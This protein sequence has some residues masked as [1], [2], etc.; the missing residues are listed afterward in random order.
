MNVGRQRSDPDLTGNPQRA[1]ETPLQDR[2]SQPLS[3]TAEDRKSQGPSDEVTGDLSHGGPYGMQSCFSIGNKNRVHFQRKSIQNED[4][5]EEVIPAQGHLTDGSFGMPHAGC[6]NASSFRGNSTHLSSHPSARLQGSDISEGHQTHRT[7]VE[8]HGRHALDHDNYTEYLELPQVEVRSATAHEDNGWSLTDQISASSSESSGSSPYLRAQAFAGH[9]DTFAR[10]KYRRHIAPEIPPSIWNNVLVH[11]TQKDYLNLRLSSKVWHSALP[12]P[13]LRATYYLPV[14]IIQQVYHYLAPQDFNAARHTCKNWYIAALDKELLALTLRKGGWWAAAEA[15]IELRTLHS[16]QGRLYTSPSYLVDGNSDDGH[17]SLSDEIWLLSKRLTIECSL[18]RGWK[19]FGL[20]SLSG[21]NRMSVCAS[22]DF[23]QLLGC[24]SQPSSASL[25]RHFTTSTCGHFVL[26][27]KDC[28]VYIYKLS[29]DTATLQGVTSVVCPR[30]VLAVSMDTS[31]RRYAIAALLEGRMG[32]VCDV[33]NM[34]P[35]PVAVDSGTVKSRK[36]ISFSN[37]W[38]TDPEFDARPTRQRHHLQ[39]QVATGAGWRPLSPHGRAQSTTSSMP[40]SQ[41]DTVVTKTAYIPN[42]D[43]A[44]PVE[45]GQR[46]IYRNLCSIDDPPRSVAICPERRCVAFGSRLGIELHWVDALSG[47]DLN[48]LVPLAAPSDHLYFL[49]PRQ[50][51]DSAKKL[52]LI[53]SA[54]GPEHDTPRDQSENAQRRHVYRRRSNSMTRLFFGN[55]PFTTGFGAS[56]SQ[57]DPSR[58][59]EY[60]TLRAIDYDHFRAIP[61]SDGIHML[62]TDPDTDHLCLGSDA[63][64]G[65]STKLLRKVKCV[66]PS[67]MHGWYLGRS[68]NTENVEIGARTSRRPLAYAAGNDLRWGVRI[69]AAYSPGHIILFSIPPD[70]LQRMKDPA[71]FRDW[72][73]RMDSDMF[74]DDFLPQEEDVFNTAV[75]ED[76]HDGSAGPRISTTT[77]AARIDGVEVG[78]MDGVVDVSVD[79]SDGGLKIWA[80]SE[81]GEARVWNVSLEQPQDRTILKTVVQSDGIV[82]VLGDFDW[83]GDAVMADEQSNTSQES[84]SGAD[85]RMP[86]H[87]ASPAEARMALPEAESPAANRGAASPKGKSR[88]VTFCDG[89]STFPSTGNQSPEIEYVN[90]QTYPLVEE[91]EVQESA[92]AWDTAL[93]ATTPFRSTR[94]YPILKLRGGGDT[95]HSI[96]WR[97]AGSQGRKRRKII[98]SDDEDSL[99]EWECE[100]LGHW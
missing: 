15:D 41:A 29:D 26:V 80:F 100:V 16:L 40:P 45:T 90:G 53:S 52:R 88:Y 7:S 28:V 75:V 58:A 85:T 44:F 37:V 98:K 21:K 34:A 71:G 64:L 91:G 13:R 51:A 54:T 92:T 19:G 2:S 65:G 32:L 5:K 66:F 61:L 55:I 18:S 23:T 43:S 49:P 94:H 12:P 39:H 81:T 14:E 25:E 84:R 97:A 10:I 59:Q 47:R 95:E 33:R 83:Q 72:F 35:S 30:K 11:L 79:C 89:S 4:A 38:G 86:S 20:R 46:S 9:R 63:P 73:H 60:G 17:E 27:P 99:E 31:F 70:L 62:F 48:R 50:D 77:C 96:M 76:A 8:Y 57:A 36:R 87:P 22:V 93:F 74:T 82:K 67:T 69:A 42:D 24:K 1:S 56:G 3:E 78:R 68:R 6:D